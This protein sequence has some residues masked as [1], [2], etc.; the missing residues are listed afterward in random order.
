[1]KDLA[2]LLLHLFALPA[3]PTV[4]VTGAELHQSLRQA[5]FALKPTT[6]APLI[7]MNDVT[8]NYKKQDAALLEGWLRA[9]EGRSEIA[10]YRAN[11][12]R[13]FEAVETGLPSYKGAKFYEYTDEARQLTISYW[14]QE[15][16]VLS[17]TAQIPTVS[18]KRSTDGVSLE[19]VLRDAFTAFEAMSQTSFTTSLDE[20][21]ALIDQMGKDQDPRL[22]YP[23]VLGDSNGRVMMST[24]IWFGI[25]LVYLPRTDVEELPDMKYWFGIYPTLPI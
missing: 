3:E 9:K 12:Q 23:L 17:V 10:D 11:L 24:A 2:I 7:T 13:S 5:N 22:G 16:N 20:A 8:E 25:T 18:F 6:I 21:M 1:M 4:P 15:Q 14:Q 19:T